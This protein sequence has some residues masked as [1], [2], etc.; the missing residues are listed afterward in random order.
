LNEA[1][2][3][4]A[5]QAV[6]ARLATSKFQEQVRKA[7]IEPSRISNARL[8]I[9]RLPDTVAGWVNGIHRRNGNNVAFVVQVDMDNGN[10]YEQ[11]RVIFVAPHDPSVELR[12]ART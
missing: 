9:T 5:P 1:P 8:T 6:A 3:S 7:G 12:S 10:R 11:Q 4:D 2:D